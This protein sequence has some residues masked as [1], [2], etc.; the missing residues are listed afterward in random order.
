[1]V[2]KY[3]LRFNLPLIRKSEKSWVF[4]TKVLKLK[5][6]KDRLQKPEQIRQKY[7]CQFVGNMHGN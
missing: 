1:M 3:S 7:T 6:K 2:V 4:E 5:C